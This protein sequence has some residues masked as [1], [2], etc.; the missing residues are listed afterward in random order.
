MKALNIKADERKDLEN[1]LQI[2]ISRFGRF[3]SKFK[4]DGMGI[5]IHYAQNGLIEVS[6]TQICPEGK[7]GL[8]IARGD[9]KEVAK[10]ICSFVDELS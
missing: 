6:N 3:L 8:G 4:F 9:I 5:E 10:Q 7:M 2:E 1:Q